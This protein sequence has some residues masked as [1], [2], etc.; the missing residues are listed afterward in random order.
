VTGT[1]AHTPEPAGSWLAARHRELLEGL[2]RHLDLDSGLREI[3]LHADHA[4]LTSALG[5]HLDT[6]AGLAAILPPPSA[7]AP[8]EAP[9]QP[10]TAAAIM[11]ADPV[12]RIALR[13]SPITTA[14]IVSYLTARALTIAIQFLARDW[15]RG[16]VPAFVRDFARA[17]DLVSPGVQELTRDLADALDRA[18]GV[19]G[20]VRGS[21]RI[22]RRARALGHALALELVDTL[23]IVLDDALANISD[24]ARAYNAYNDAGALAATLTDI[25]ALTDNRALPLSQALASTSGL[26]LAHAL[27]GETA[28]MVGDALGLRQV[29]GLAAAL[30]EGALD[31]FTHA[32]LA[33]ADLTGHD[34]TGIRWSD[35]GTT[36]PPG[37]DTGALRAQSREVADGS[38]IYVITG[39]GHDDKARHHT[40]T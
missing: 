24:L 40:H 13:R 30:L 8:R 34:L 5:S 38:G 10:G 12:A 26:D 11:A 27:A 31:D 6:Q 23:R 1:P 7:A 14:A 39:P 16:S 33:R 37:T 25:R 28:L 22:S 15:G 36:W 18:G 32:D 19:L 35:W 17:Q 20:P 3:M 4:G 29:E 21:R 2:S 9:G